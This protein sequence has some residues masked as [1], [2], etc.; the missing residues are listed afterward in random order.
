MIGV[1]SSAVVCSVIGNGASTEAPASD[2]NVAEGR[3][4]GGDGG[5]AIRDEA[6]G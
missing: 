5:E 3:G 1:Y 4:N 2:G 6:E